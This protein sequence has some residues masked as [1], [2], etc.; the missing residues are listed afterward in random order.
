MRWPK[1]V[2]QGTAGVVGDAAKEEE[3]EEELVREEE[4][5]GSE[6]AT[7]GTGAIEGVVVVDV[8]VVAM[9]ME[10]AGAM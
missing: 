9:G 8:E 2:A 6:E 5:R 4:A 3:E 10:A 1:G 7:E